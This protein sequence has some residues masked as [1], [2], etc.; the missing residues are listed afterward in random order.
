MA[1]NEKNVVGSQPASV[2][3]ITLAARRIDV[4]VNAAMLAA[5]D[6]VCEHEQVTVTEAVRRL[7]SYGD[8][9]YE[10]TKVR[11]VTLVVCGPDGDEREV[12]ML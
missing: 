1:K 4:A 5:I 2:Q 12:L 3:S 10:T 6:R 9:V 8:L 11:G 7:I